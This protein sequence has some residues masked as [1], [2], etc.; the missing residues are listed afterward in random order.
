[1][2][3]I[4]LQAAARDH[5]QSSVPGDRACPVEPNALERMRFPH[6]GDASTGAFACSAVFLRGTRFLGYARARCIEQFSGWLG[7]GL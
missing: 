5:A 1:M 2:S 7:S 4:D 3:P 6:R